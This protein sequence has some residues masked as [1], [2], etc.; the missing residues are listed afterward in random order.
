MKKL[1][2]DQMSKIHGG[3]DSCNALLKI[4]VV[5]CAFASVTGPIGALIFGPTCVGTAIGYAIGC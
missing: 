1:N 5:S 2:L 4:T 3:V